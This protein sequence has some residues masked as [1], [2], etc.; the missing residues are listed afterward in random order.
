MSQDFFRGLRGDLVRGLQKRDPH[1]FAKLI[2]HFESIGLE[3][4]RKGERGGSL[5]PVS[6]KTRLFDREPLESTRLR[7][8]GTTFVLGI[9]SQGLL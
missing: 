2:P 8:P 6:T 7:V 1:K 5:N 4:S 9:S 3:C